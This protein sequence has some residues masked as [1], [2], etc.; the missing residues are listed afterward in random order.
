MNEQIQKK[1]LDNVVFEKKQTKKQDRY[2][3]APWERKMR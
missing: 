2:A 1:N 3:K